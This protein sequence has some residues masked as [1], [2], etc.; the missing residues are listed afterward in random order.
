MNSDLIVLKNFSTEFIANMACEPIG[1]YKPEY[2]VELIEQEIYKI[3]LSFNIL[4]DVFQDDWRVDVIPG[5]NP[6]FHWSPH[7]TPTEEYIISQQV[8]RTPA[9]IVSDS[10]RQII[11]IPDLDIMS[12][13]NGIKWYMD[14][15]AEKNKMT[16]GMS[17]YD[18]KEHVL[19][20]RKKGTKYS[21]GKVEIGFYIMLQKDK[22]DIYDPWRKPLD[23]IW[24]RWG[25]DLYY[26]G[27]PLNGSLDSYVD[28]TYNWAFKEWK[29]SVWQEFDIDGKHVGG[30]SFIVNVT[31]SP[32]YTGNMRERE[33]K[34][35]WNQ[36][37]FSSLSSAQ[38]FYRYG[39]KNNNKALMDK[40]QMV[41]E[42]ALC[43]P[44]KKGFFP[45]VL[46][47]EMESVNING[48]TV[49]RSKGWD[50]RYW[51]NSD[52]NPY[53]GIKSAP[54]HVLDMS[55]TAFLM[56]TW[57]EELEKDNR[58]VEYVSNYINNL[59]NMQD[60]KGFF[61]SWIDKDN[62]SPC[63]ELSESP[64]TSMTV[65][66]LLKL[67]NI[68]ENQKY[69]TAATKA[70]KAVINNIV[71]DGRWEDFET[72]WSCSSYG[73]TDLVGKKVSRNN[74]YKQCNFS[75]YLT[76]EALYYCYKTTGDLSYL[77]IGQRCLD[78]MLM[79]QASWQPPFMYVNTLGG[80][81]VMNCDGEWNDARSSLFA[82]LIVQYGIILDVK[83][84]VERGLAAM[85]SSFVMMYCPENVKEK[86]QWE[87]AWPF[88]NEKD[89]GFTMENYSHSGLADNNG[90]G[91]G[92]FTIFDWGNGSAAECYN[93]LV[94]HFGRELIDN[95]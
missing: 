94:D 7:L 64:E 57:Y 54:Y 83:E 12:K 70:I 22:N 63:R 66:V 39:R 49:N 2:S 32:N 86:E 84:Y 50:S 58:L 72:Y 91:I 68:T 87:K 85:R 89:Y 27:K 75:M 44:Q 90:I 30:Q 16:L 51:G 10:T 48:E 26:S 53:G 14:L 15:D 65:S 81:G 37:W 25:R 3:N 11:F 43:A 35:I 8:F 55:R 41:K 4:E 67:Y 95:L 73:S 60:K 31:Q 36:A 29:S 80:F 61:P 5:F 62:N 1:E 9:L 46:A 47:T 6:T 88:F 38:G 19:F 69:L 21:K 59:L 24:G 18:V 76:A 23:F 13:D 52:R 74:M 28:Y 77:K 92:E 82:E 71:F 93:R 79:T 42:L 78:E 34:S 56:L 33:I 45:S 17:E 20:V 40:A